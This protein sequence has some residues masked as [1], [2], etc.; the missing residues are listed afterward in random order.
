MGSTA[1]LWH[2]DGAHV[3]MEKIVLLKSVN[4]I[5]STKN[6]PKTTRN[7]T[8]VTNFYENKQKRG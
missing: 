1:V 7:H 5:H 8:T 3:Q 2:R 6:A 4:G